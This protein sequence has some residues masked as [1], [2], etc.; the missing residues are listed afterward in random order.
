MAGLF[1]F[2]GSNNMFGMDSSFYSNLS[3]YNSIRSGA[4]R[5]AAKSYYKTAQSNGQ[6]NET[7]S[8]NKPGSKPNSKVDTAGVS[9]STTKAA[10]KDLASSAQKLS[11]NDKN[12]VFADKSKYDKDEAYKA[13]NDFVNKYNDTV[14]ALKKTTSTGV[15]NAGNSMTRMTD[16]MSKG[17]SKVGISVGSDGKMSIDEDAFKKANASDVR[18]MFNGKGSYA[19]I[20]ESSA[21]RIATQATNQ[22]NQTSGSMYGVDGYFNSYSSGAMYNNYF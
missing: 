22:I 15:N 21:S 2:S 10:A 16:V 9:L 4:Y 5:K 1:G 18:S 8:A 17:L 11:S 12:G 3:Q 19:S 13:V 6:T 14:D 7:E 20:V